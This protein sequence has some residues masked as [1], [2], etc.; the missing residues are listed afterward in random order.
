MKKIFIIAGEAS[1]DQLGAGL[2]RALREK[3]DALEIKG[4]G[5]E[6]MAAEEFASLFPMQEISLM[7]FAEILPHIPRL[8]KRIKQTVAAIEE[9]QPDAVITID[10]PGFNFRVAKALRENGKIKAKMIHYVAPTVWAYK[11]ER[12]QKTAALFDHLMV[13]LP[14]EPPY[15]EEV[16]LATS[17]VGHPV[18]DDLDAAFARRTVRSDDADSGTQFG[19]GGSEQGLVKHRCL[20]VRHARR[21]RSVSPSSC[22]P[23]FCNCLR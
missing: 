23:G 5:G 20:L 11:P 7:G 4:I 15:F 9:F 18:A 21:A 10:S 22:A 3:E 12:A 16:G 17:F 1:G 19:H 14:F 6:R 2:L 13:L 8:L